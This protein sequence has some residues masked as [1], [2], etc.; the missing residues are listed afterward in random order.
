[1]AHKI[2]L[3]LGGNLG[4]RLHWLQYG[5]HHIANTI[6][7]VVQVSPVYETAAWGKEAQPAF[8]NRVLEVATDLTP[9]QVLER[10]T[11]IEAA[12]GRQREEVWG[13]RTLDIDILF[14][15][16]L[17]V[18]KPHLQIPHPQISNRRFTL[19][20]LADIAPTLVHPT[21]HLTI[22]ELLAGCPDPLPVKV[23]EQQK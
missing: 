8:L 20:P 14:Y 9:E 2:Y 16:D 13:A 5:Q 12:A 19:Q 6:G 21:L 10:T 17:Q 4:N 23:F 7:E 15:D 1:M 11:A 22:T 18:A 3:L